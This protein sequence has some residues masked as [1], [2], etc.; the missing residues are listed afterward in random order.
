MGELRTEYPRPNFVRKSYQNLNGT[1]K[2]A[3]DDENK[4]EFEKWFEG[5]YYMEEIQVPFVYQSKLSGIGEKKFH[6]ILWYERE[7]RIEEDISNKDVLIHFGAVY[8]MVKVYVNGK[9]AAIHEGGDTPF[10]VNADEFL[11]KEA[12][13]Q[14]ITLRVYDPCTDETI[15]RGKQFWEEKERGIWYTPSSGI[16]QSVWIEA[17]PKARIEK[18]HFISRFDEGKEEIKCFI[19]GGNDGLKIHAEVRFKEELIADVS[20]LCIGSEAS[21]TVDLIQ[22]H[23][24]R[25]NFHNDGR[26]WTPENPNLYDVI[27]RLERIDGEVLDEVGS[28]FGFRKIHVENRMI[29]L[30]NKPYYQ[31]LVLDQGYW[32]D[33]LLTAPDDEALRYD[34]EAAKKLGFNGCRKHQ[35]AEDPRFLYWADKLGYLVW[36]ECASVPTFGEDQVRREMSL[37]SAIVERD[38]NHPSIVCWVP[39][40]E[41]WGVPNIHDNR[42][43]QHYSKMF[44]HYLHTLDPTRLVISND[45]WEMTVTDIC[46]IHNYEH[47]AVGDDK[48][49]EEF[50]KMFESREELLNHPCGVWDI[51][52]KGNEDEG[53]PIVITEFGGI[54]FDIDGNEENGWGYSNAETEEQFVS[55]YRRVLEPIA[56]SNALSGYCYTQLTDVEQEINGFMTY[57]RKWKC[58]PQEIYEINTMYHR[59][60]V[61]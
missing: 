49:A 54:G 25:T 32:P 35:K 42:Q 47:G 15:P 56:R 48:K 3:F 30:N 59:L 28:Y 2:F 26:A 20:M 5:H 10:T 45:G 50:E 39:L 17:V 61:K 13:K 22:N 6:D 37:W 53:V 60:R 33:S 27:L 52:A 19:K 58:D 34:I 8:Y 16:W 9:F 7:F 40:N 12:E 41:S 21:M 1:W 4:G 44:Y 57:D 11:N 24:F 31:R 51:Y 46:A 55:E 38:F 14:R 36:G 43:Q 29:Y 18:V 23:I